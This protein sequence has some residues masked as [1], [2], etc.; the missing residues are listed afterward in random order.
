MAIGDNSYGSVA[1]VA[2][3]TGRWTNEGSYDGTT[4]P[5]LTQ[6]E[7]FIDRVSGMLNL[8]LAE[9]GFAVP[10]SQADAKLV[11]DEFVVE[12]AVQLCH[13]ANGAG[14]FAPGSEQLRSRTAFEIISREASE[15]VTAH[16]AGFGFLG[17]TRSRDLTYGLQ[18]TLTDTSGDDLEK[19]FTREDWPDVG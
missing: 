2:A 11:C 10:V 6:V 4:R 5:T 19:M 8:L 15:F 9:A 17:A 16:A 13:G 14:P 3:L 7:T 12:Q 1:E 18:A